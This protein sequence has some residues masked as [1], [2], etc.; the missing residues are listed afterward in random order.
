[1]NVRRLALPLAFAVISVASV[2]CA[3]WSIPGTGNDPG[4]VRDAPPNP[5]GDVGRGGAGGGNVGGGVVVPDPGGGGDPADGSRPSI[6]TPV[7][8][9]L[10]PTPVSVWKM[11][12]S[13]D[14]RHVTVLL[15][16]WS[17]VAPCSVLDSVDVSRDGTTITMTPREGTDPN[18]GNQVACPAI[19]MLRGTIVD[20]GELEPGTWTLVA[21]GDLAP[22]TITV[23]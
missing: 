7:P 4:G 23:E 2:G 1:M 15:S 11:E 21:N 5:G 6:E 8:G 9:Q 3:G 17:G 12:P 13:V 16:W 18:A 20:L 14:G 22:V 19:A 10:N